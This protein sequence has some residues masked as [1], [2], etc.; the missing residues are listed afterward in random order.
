MKWLYKLY[1]MV[2]TEQTYQSYQQV[3]MSLA[4]LLSKDIFILPGK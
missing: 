4:N 2:N 1:K 3:Q